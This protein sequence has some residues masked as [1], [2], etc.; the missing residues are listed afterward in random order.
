MRIYFKWKVA[1]LFLPGPVSQFSRVLSGMCSQFNLLTCATQKSDFCPQ[2]IDAGEAALHQ[3]HCPGIAAFI[4]IFK[5]N[6]YGK[7]SGFYMSRSC[8]TAIDIQSRTKRFLDSRWIQLIRTE[9]KESCRLRL[10]EVIHKSI[11][12]TAFPGIL[13][14]DLEVGNFWGWF[15]QKICSGSNS[16]RAPFR[17]KY[18]KLAKKSVKRT[19][20]WTH[21]TWKGLWNN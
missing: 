9:L 14:W 8:F 17:E 20:D 3:H 10:T 16:P 5:H 4:N 19:E 12:K 15:S 2:R 7:E 1:R 13:L 18:R 6:I 21:E 11:H